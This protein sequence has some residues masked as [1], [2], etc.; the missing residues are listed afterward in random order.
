MI[1]MTFYSRDAQPAK[2]GMTSYPME[3]PRLVELYLLNAR[4]LDRT[5][6][7]KTI[8][9]GDRLFCGIKSRLLILT[10]H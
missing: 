6:L 8:V 2:V 7:Q 3:P 9:G 4:H 1:V 5:A 10:V